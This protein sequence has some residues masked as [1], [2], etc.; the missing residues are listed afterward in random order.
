M[1]TANEGR[2]R[3]ESFGPSGKMWQRIEL[4]DPRRFVDVKEALHRVAQG[5]GARS[6]ALEVVLEWCAV[7]EALRH[8]IQVA[9]VAQIRK[10]SE[11]SLGNA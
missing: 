10:A 1:S 8:G 3:E 4:G 5:A 11:R 6:L 2:V 7:E 9:S